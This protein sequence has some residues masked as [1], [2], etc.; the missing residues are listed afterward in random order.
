MPR[1]H[2][3][4]PSSF[5]K[6]RRISKRFVLSRAVITICV[7]FCHGS[8]SFPALRCALQFFPTPY[9]AAAPGPG[10]S[11][12]RTWQRE[13]PSTPLVEAERPSLLEKRAILKHFVLLYAIITIRVCFCCDILSFSAY[14]CGSWFYAISCK[15]YLLVTYS[16]MSSPVSNGCIYTTNCNI[17]KNNY[18]TCC[19]LA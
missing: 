7:P 9:Y 10:S 4:S 12:G 13:Y 5:R 8:L 16:S 1:R 14:S 17:S 3:P 15:G 2:G 19:I 18:H 6:K 11:P